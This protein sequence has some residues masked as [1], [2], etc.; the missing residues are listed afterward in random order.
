M[1]PVANLAKKSR[2]RRVPTADSLA[3]TVGTSVKGADGV[4]GNL[5]TY[6]CDAAGCAT[7]GHPS[8]EKQVGSI[9]TREC[10]LSFITSG[11]TGLTGFTHRTVHRCGCD[12][13]FSCH[14]NLRQHLRVHKGFHD[15]PAGQ[16]LQ[17]TRTISWKRFYGPEVNPHI[18]V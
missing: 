18:C 3:T 2:G 12:K 10:F 6:T 1:V 9:H 4:G 15:F 13:D 14:D 17:S 5:R 11:L 16:G 8:S 7:E